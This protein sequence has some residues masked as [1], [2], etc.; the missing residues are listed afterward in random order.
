M[1]MFRCDH[2]GRDFKV[3]TSLRRHFPIHTGVRKYACDV[4]EKT[5]LQASTLSRHRAV[6]TFDKPYDCDICHKAFNR[7]ST[8]VAHQKIHLGEKKYKCEFCGRA[9]HQ[10]GNLKNHTYTHTG[11][12]PHQCDLCYKEFNQASNLKFHMSTVHSKFT[13]KKVMCGECGFVFYTKAELKLHYMDIHGMVEK[14]LDQESDASS[15]PA[16]PSVMTVSSREIEKTIATLAANAPNDSNY[17]KILKLIRQGVKIITLD[18]LSEWTVESPAMLLV[19]NSWSQ[20]MTNLALSE[21]KSTVSGSREHSPTADHGNS[22]NANDKKGD[23]DN[24]DELGGGDSAG[25]QIEKS[26]RTGVLDG[27]SDG[28]L[29]PDGSVWALA[30]MPDGTHKVINVKE[31]GS[32]GVAAIAAGASLEKVKKEIRES[33]LETQQKSGPVLSSKVQ[34]RKGILAGGTSAERGS[35]VKTS[36]IVKILS[37]SPRAHKR[38][39]V[40]FVESESFVSTASTVQDCRYIQEQLVQT[41]PKHHR[42]VSPFVK[43]AATLLPKPSEAQ[44]SLL[45]QPAKP[46]EP[47]KSLLVPVQPT[48]V[49]KVQQTTKILPTSKSPTQ[50]KQP[51]NTVLSPSVPEVKIMTPVSTSPSGSSSSLSAKELLCVKTALQSQQTSG[52]CLWKLVTDKDGK[53]T[54]IG[55]KGAQVSLMGQKVDEEKTVANTSEFVVQPGQSLISPQKLETQSPTAPAKKQ[56]AVPVTVYKTTQSL[57]SA[58]VGKEGQAV[59]APHSGASQFDLVTV[60][61]ASGSPKEVTV[62][63]RTSASKLSIAAQITRK[64]VTVASPS[65]AEKTVFLEGSV[66]ASRCKLVTPDSLGPQFTRK[67]T[68]TQRRVSQSSPEPFVVS[69]PAE[70]PKYVKIVPP[71]GAAAPVSIVPDADFQKTGVGSHTVK[72][73]SVSPQDVAN[74]RSSLP[75]PKLGSAFRKRPQTVAEQ[76]RIKRATISPSA[77]AEQQQTVEP[78]VRPNAKAEQQQIA[79]SIAHLRQIAPKPEPEQISTIDYETK[80]NMVEM[81]ANVPRSG[82]LVSLQMVDQQGQIQTPLVLQQQGVSQAVTTSPSKTVPTILRRKIPSKSGGGQQI[83]VPVQITPAG[84]KRNIFEGSLSSTQIGV[85]TSPG[86]VILQPRPPTTNVNDIKQEQDFNDDNDDDENS[87][88]ME[89]AAK[90]ETETEDNIV[91]LETNL[92]VDSSAVRSD[93]S[94]SIDTCAV[95]SNPENDIDT[96]V[97]TVIES[98]DIKP[99]E[100]QNNEDV[101]TD[102]KSDCDHDTDED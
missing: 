77:E 18:D 4:C 61:H 89:I 15:Q 34:P 27:S 72:V 17:Q 83:F 12:K 76:L 73:I 49:A 101:E 10:K 86:F 80:L 54:L 47:G 64:E 53:K 24:A 22:D 75:S 74:K 30:K 41:R 85:A 88:D 78:I 84:A 66:D 98:T 16:T 65:G 36:E 81:G 62:I 28:D 23:K 31:L 6:H 97:K 20:E 25:K 95:K 48:T 79:E 91:K 1:R 82:G 29:P 44:R 19:P 26:D 13:G 68:Y 2:C 52:I 39:S 102:M 51:L 38:H 67:R 7:R 100:Q 45:I 11:E 5:F 69:E 9:F 8:L 14:E 32:S 55:F 70:A 50:N 37:S 40:T 42:G 63:P 3:M 99:N 56:K 60:T 87:I 57:L 92:N 43:T 96:E 46:V 33:A 35:P 93:S 71:K 58:N 94:S 59:A 90:S 21:A